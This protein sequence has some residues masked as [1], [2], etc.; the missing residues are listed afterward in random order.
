VVTELIDVVRHGPASRYP[1]GA[2]APGFG[3][4]LFCEFLAHLFCG[5]ADHL[6]QP[7][8]IPQGID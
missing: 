5:L 3:C 4:F 8:I 7:C 1:P 6:L 2:F